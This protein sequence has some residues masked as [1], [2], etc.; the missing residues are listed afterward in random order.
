M[1]RRQ[2]LD[3]GPEKRVT[4]NPDAAHIEHDAV[5]IEVDALAQLDVR[6]VVAKKRGLH[7]DRVA[8]GA[9]QCFNYATPVG[10]ICL[11]CS[12]QRCAEVAGTFALRH[13]LRVH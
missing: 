1:K 3:A 8:T 4:A 6:A 13:E 11:T 5:E 2:D 12:V 9:E 7:P 10:L